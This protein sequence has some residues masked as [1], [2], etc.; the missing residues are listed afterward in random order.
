MFRE[1][2]NNVLKTPIQPYQI[3][4]P[5]PTQLYKELQTVLGG[6]GRLTDMA[7]PDGNC[8]FRSVSKEL[9]GTQ[10]HHAIIRE[11]L[12]EFIEQN[13]A[14]FSKVTEMFGRSFPQ[15]CE[16]LKRQGSWA[17]TTELLALASWLQIPVYVFSNENERR[18][19]WNR[20]LP[21]SPSV[22][23]VN[24]QHREIRRLTP[25]LPYHIELAYTASSHFDRIQPP[26]SYC[27]PTLSGQEISNTRI[28]PVILN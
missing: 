19:I 7:L 17:T 25:P 22:N 12:I 8:F 3:L 28:N 16:L 24:D 14:H 11:L 9:L 13:G 23:D 15:H 1:Q 18:W 26:P 27:P 4:T 2:L 6:T 20:Y 21:V 5:P 10:A